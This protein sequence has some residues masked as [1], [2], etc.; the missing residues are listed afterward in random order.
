MKCHCMFFDESYSEKYYRADTVQRFVDESDCLI[1]VGTD[2]VTN[3]AAS[4]VDDYVVRDLPIIEINL[5]SAIDRGNNI[6]VLG[7]LEEELPALFAEYYR[8]MKLKA[9][10][11]SEK[12]IKKKVEHV[13][14]RI[15]EL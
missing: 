6:Q 11:K 7:K 1:V 9:K 13:D 14:T 15:S 3:F 12:Q 10:I 8:L 4:I 5:E 2:L